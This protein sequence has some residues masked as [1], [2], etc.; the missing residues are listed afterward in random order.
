M[1][2]KIS[3][4]V[5]VFLLSISFL[6]ITIS[7]RT[8]I[9]D[10]YIKN[11][12]TEIIVN[13][14][15]SLLITEKITADCDSLPNKH[16]I[17]RIVPYE[18]RTDTGIIKMPIK[19]ISITDFNGHPYKYQTILDI[20]NK[21]ITWKIGDP[22]KT[23]TGENNYQI[24][25]QIS[26]AI[27]FSNESFDE[28]YHNL[29][30]GFWQLEIDN[31]SAKVIFPQEINKN[32]TQ[33]YLYSGTN[34]EKSNY[35]A[36]Y[37]WLNEHI[38]KVDS[39]PGITIIPGQAITLSAAMPKGIFKQPSNSQIILAQTISFIQA[40]IDKSFLWY[41]LP[42]IVFI[43][44]FRIWQKHGKDLKLSK[45]PIIPEYDVPFD[46][47][48]LEVSLL[49]NDFLLRNEAITATLIYF[50]TKGLITIEEKEENKFIFKTK[51]FVFHREKPFPQELQNCTAE[52]YLFNLLFQN[53]EVKETTLESFSERYKKMKNWKNEKE[54]WNA[55]YS[56]FTQRDLVSEKSLRLRDKL[57]Y[58]GVGI[59]LGLYLIWGFSDKFNYSYS[60]NFF[61]ALILT[62][63]IIFL[64]AALMPQLTLKGQEA[65]WRLKGF[66]LYLETAEKYR[67]QF[68]EKENI[69]EKFLPYAIIFKMTNLWIKKMKQI[70]GE[71]YMNSHTPT[72]YVSS[73]NFSMPSMNFNSF[74]SSLS[75]LSSSISSS[76]GGSSGVGGG[77]SAGGGGGGGGGGG[78]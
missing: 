36:N 11:Y 71:E 63:I 53:D 56:D 42:L 61:I 73:S 8:N 51:K 39:L 37:Y 16:G 66:K 2:K 48:P 25:Y 58:F 52:K 47:T 65:K 26:N 12:D 33:V 9:Y 15:S 22:R 10:W 78:W 23:V 40:I 3:I 4:L 77:G 69:F 27:R 50:A 6:P 28:L 38:L 46:L 57:I 19:L 44:C 14:D 62:D 24:V 64:F 30:G 72:W 43:I 29:L 60:A 7:A 34:N 5:S 17:F 70:Y 54:F 32:N 13:K 75:S 49:L 59:I 74:A 18:I 31:F 55:I 45:K 41:L 35:L 21:T 67:E 20:K 76:V 1:M 68:Y